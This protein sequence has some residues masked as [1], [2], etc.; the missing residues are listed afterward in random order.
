MRDRIELAL[1]RWG[2]F[3][4]RRAGWVIAVILLATAAFATQL[5]YFYLDASTEGFFHADDPVR[6]QYDRFRDAYG[7]ESLILVA[8]VPRDGVFEQDFLERLRVL[9]REIED[10]VPYLTEV[11]SLVNARDTRGFD[12][13]LEVGEFLDTWP[14]TPEALANAE[15]RARANRIYRNNLLSEDGT[16]TTIAIETDVY[17]PD[18]DADGLDGFDDEAGF[19]PETEAAEPQYLSG[20]YDEQI[21]AALEEVLSRHRSDDLE[22]HIAGSPVFTTALSASIQRD[23]ARFTGLCFLFIAILLAVLFRRVGAVVLPLVTVALTVIS[24][25]AVM[26]ATGTPVMPPTQIIPSFLLAVGVGGAVHLLAIFYQARRRG[27]DEE[28]AVSYALSH[29]GLPIIMTCLTTAGGLLSFVPAALRPISHFG[30]FTPVGVL[31]SLF[32]TL[33]LLPAM[34]AVFP[35]RAA[36]ARRDN[37]ASQRFLLRVGALATRRRALVVVAWTALLLGSGVGLARLTLNHHM[38]EWFPAGDATKEATIFLNEKM[39]GAASLELLVATGR[40]NGFHEPE[41]LRKLDRIQRDLEALEVGHVRAGK[42][43]ALTDVVKETHRALNENRD[44]FYD[45]PGERTLIAQELLL[46]ENTGSD[47]VEDFVDSQFSSGRITVRMPFTDAASYDPYLEVALAGIE[48]ELGADATVE[49]TGLLRL[50]ANTVTAAL[51]TMILSY[52]SAFI[53]ITVLM[54]MLIGSLRMGLVAMIPNVVPI[55]FTLGLMGWLDIPLDMFT[56]MIGTIAIGLAVDDTIHFMHNFRRYYDA[57][58]DPEEAVQRT[59]VGAG[60]AMLFTTLVLATGFLVYTQA[61]MVNLIA[62]GLLTTTAITLAFIADVTLAP[63]LVTMLTRKRS[64]A[65][66][67]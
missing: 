43:L 24:T 12:D 46:F 33:T 49:A 7:R 40:N 35:M 52:V 19:G 60:Q 54:V 11:T 65:P 34:I 56:L 31:I 6:V 36:T 16:I 30:A 39:G 55:V 37:A 42:T 2:R 32:F 25:L 10:E 14:D 63:A 44:A 13:R 21:V 48:R 50:L 26:A 67:A 61:Y 66:P 28:S 53:V 59:L 41:L 22:I 29:S 18:D 5:Q 17:A 58:G 64:G 3:V 62:F 38:L 8:L 1:G 20:R 23:M 4:Y 51:K 57:T 9:H 47:D 15:R 45:I 27:D